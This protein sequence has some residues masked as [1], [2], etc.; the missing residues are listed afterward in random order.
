MMCRNILQFYVDNEQDP[1]PSVDYAKDWLDQ[2]FLFPGLIW[3]G[4]EEAFTYGF[5]H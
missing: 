5:D 4:L 1:V 2:S 3:S